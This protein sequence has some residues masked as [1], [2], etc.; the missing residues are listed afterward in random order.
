MAKLPPRSP[1][2][3]VKF[4]WRGSHFVGQAKTFGIHVFDGLG[5]KVA[6]M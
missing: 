1:A 5:V 3:Q 2:T 4:E 6:C